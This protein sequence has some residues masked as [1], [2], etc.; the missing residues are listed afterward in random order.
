VRIEKDMPIRSKHIYILIEN[1]NV[2]VRNG[3]F[4]LKKRGPDLVNRCINIFFNSLAMDCGN[5][6]IAIIMSGGGDDGLEGAIKIYHAGGKVLVQ[7]PDSAEV[8]GMPLAIL[9]NDHPKA[10]MSPEKLALNL[11][12]FITTPK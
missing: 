3:C 11:N 7:D 8:N 10:A 2:E 4:V 6:S 9:K 1:T 5:K 12:N